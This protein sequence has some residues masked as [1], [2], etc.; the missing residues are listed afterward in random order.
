M[1]INNIL[2]Y[3]NEIAPCH[4]AENFD[5]VGLIIDTGKK[6]I[7]KVMLALDVTDNVVS[8]AIENNIDMIITHHPMIFSKIKKIDN[9]PLGKR[10][11]KLIKHNIS[12]Y[13]SHTNLDKSPCGTNNYLFE[14]LEFTNKEPLDNGE[15]SSCLGLI[16]ET[17]LNIDDLIIKVKK[18]LGLE[19]LNCYFSNNNLISKVAILTGSGCDYEYLQY[20]ITKNCNVFISGD[21]TYHKAQFAIENG[22]TIIDASHYATEFL[23]LDNMKKLIED[24]FKDIDIIITKTNGQILK[25]V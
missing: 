25:I 13:T 3:M 7:N 4:I 5:N 21:A 11:V 1:H 9:S 15:L 17:N 18:V 23:V 12:V 2:E 22:L 20:A 6:N 10:I 8:E 16:G 19:Y 24:K 14:K